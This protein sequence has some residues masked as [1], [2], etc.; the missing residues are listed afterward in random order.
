M[1]KVEVGEAGAFHD[2]PRPREEAVR[3]LE[4]RAGTD[5]RRLFEAY[6]RK[7]DK[8]GSGCA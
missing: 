7:V 2:K 3:K 8:L 5:A 6:L 1:L 4:E